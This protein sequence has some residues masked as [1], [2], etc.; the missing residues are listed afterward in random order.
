M[1]RSRK[2]SVN[3]RRT[4]LRGAGFGP[5]AVG[6]LAAERVSE[7]VGW[8]RGA[9]AAAGRSLES[10]ELQLSIYLCQ[11]T[12]SA[13]AAG[14]ATSAFSDLIRADTALVENS[15]AVL[16]GTAQQ[17]IDAL[18]ERRER[19]GFSYIKLGGDIEAVAPI[20]SRLAGR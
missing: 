8:V 1:L 11:V 5:A 3:G 4:P 14:T 16:V 7:K 19:F 12:D 6:D 20:V 10:F 9:A 17:C 15:P 13:S 2:D 18:C